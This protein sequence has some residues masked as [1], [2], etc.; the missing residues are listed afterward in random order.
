[1]LKLPWGEPRQ[2]ESL[3]VREPRIGQYQNMKTHRIRCPDHLFLLLCIPHRKYATKLVHMDVCAFS[4]DQLFFANL[5]THY[6]SMRGRWVS[7]FSVRKLKCIR[8]V[9]F[10]VYKSELVDIRKINDIPPEA[11]NDEYRYRPL[12]AEVVP[13]VGENHM[14]HLYEHPEDA[15]DTAVCLDKIPKNFQERL[16]VSPQ[17]VTG[18]GWG[19]HFVEGLHWMKLWIL[20]LTGLLASVVFGV[21]W[22]TLKNDV[23]GGFGIAACLMVGLTFTTGILQA[24]LEP[25]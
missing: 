20:G 14:M 1:M 17:K 5:K 22:S 6:Q 3:P 8:F 4:S 25:K 15:D 11:K 23:Q 9:Q 18:L 10:E 19:I 21:L 2:L 7:F 24:A 16:L 13:P 12:P